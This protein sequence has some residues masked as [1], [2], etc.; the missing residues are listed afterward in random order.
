MIQSMVEIFPGT[1]E[2]SFMVPLVPPSS[3]A[4]PAASAEQGQSGKKQAHTGKPRG[5]KPGSGR[6]ASANKVLK[7]ISDEVQVDN[8][9]FSASAANNS[10]SVASLTTESFASDE[11]KVL[12]RKRSRNALDTIVT[13]TH[14]PKIF[15]SNPVFPNQV[16][17]P[18]QNTH[19]PYY[20]Q[21]QFVE[22]HSQSNHYNPYHNNSYDI[23]AD[24]GQVSMNQDN[25]NRLHYDIVHYNNCAPSHFPNRAH[26]MNMS[27]GVYLDDSEIVAM[28]NMADLGH[29]YHPVGI[30]DQAA[31]PIYQNEQDWIRML[32]SFSPSFTSTDNM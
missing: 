13:D 12:Q 22:T 20:S 5:R 18:K 11:G 9:Q 10:T 26:Q 29:A 24:F 6:R 17:S 19:S 2:K 3:L 14:S 28:M 1:Q 7:Q 25:R 31:V 16:V 30:K 23:R 4:P 21:N 15:Y 27:E 8:S 32:D